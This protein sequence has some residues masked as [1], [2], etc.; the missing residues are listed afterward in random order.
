VR[1]SLGLSLLAALIAALS[2]APAASAE[3]PCTKTW[4]GAATGD[5]NEAANWAP[6]G[7][8]G[9]ADVVCIGAGTDTTVDAAFTIATLRS[10]GIVRVSG[11]SSD[12]TITDAAEPSSIDEFHLVAAGLYGD[13]DV[14]IRRLIWGATFT[15]IE[16]G[17][18]GT[19]TV[20]EYHELGDANQG[21]REGRTLITEGTGTWSPN[22]FRAY[23][24]ALWINR[25]DVTYTG[26]GSLNATTV[27]EE[28]PVFRNEAG[29]S[30][31]RTGGGNRNIRLAV[32]NDGV[33]EDPDGFS[34]NG[35]LRVGEASGT[36]TGEFLGVKVEGDH[37]F[38]DGALLRDSQVFDDNTVTP[39]ATVEMDGGQI[40]GGSIVGPGTIVLS[41][42]LTAT[43][44]RFGDAESLLVVP[45]GAHLHWTAAMAFTPRRFE[46]HGTV[47]ITGTG[48][49]HPPGTFGER[50]VWENT[51][52][53]ILHAGWLPVFAGDE[54]ARI[55]NHGTIV[56]TSTSTLEV[57][58]TI[59]ND[60]LV[61]VQLG[62]LEANRFEQTADGTLRFGIEGEAARTEH[63]EL[64]A[65]QL[66]YSGRLE[67]EL[68]NDYEPPDD[69]VL[70]VIATP[71]SNRSGSFLSTALAGLALD[72][73]G[74]TAITLLGPEAEPGGPGGV[75]FAFAPEDR[76]TGAA[77]PAPAAPPDAPSS[78]STAR[79]A[80]PPRARRDRAA[81][82]R[83][84]RSVSRRS[85]RRRHSSSKRRTKRAKR[86]GR[87][88]AG[89]RRRVAR[90][91]AVAR[92]ATKARVKRRS[93]RHRARAK[94]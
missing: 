31:T 80:A 28:T 16:M 64:L 92:C 78:A 39:G 59:V 24:D 43:F 72:E 23:G 76:L 30:V 77:T 81:C 5:W 82:R 85:S 60:G 46:T 68:R 4:S 67:A 41:G 32:E 17:G 21:L 10:E 66:R 49:G 12:L 89:R 22:S 27:A 51:G 15:G 53:L 34:E 44:G 91:S 93:A 65:S 88:S 36:S 71:A 40:Y 52:T 86:G 75:A 84:A 74:S 90:R 73:T 48:A 26:G 2:P 33:I 79:T 13:A 61:D 11:N 55:V 70:Y 38:G 18:T 83:R 47:E 1:R 25:A 42:D 57:E 14:T 69:A 94:S 37:V 35:Y 58:P 56:K 19:T 6:V 50:M 20:T 54:R 45:V 29:A 62:R 8:P 7:V 87:R 9:A 3:A 63:G